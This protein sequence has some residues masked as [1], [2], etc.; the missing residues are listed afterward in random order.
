MVD[1]P[2][3]KAQCKGCNKHPDALSEY[4]DIA[5]EEDCTPTEY[6]QHNEGTYNPTTGKFWCTECYIRVG[7]PLGQA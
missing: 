5:K 1:F 6:V 4:V 2:F 3:P 7:M